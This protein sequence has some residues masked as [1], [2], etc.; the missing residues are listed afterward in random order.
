MQTKKQSFIEAVVNIFI[1]YIVAVLSQML[2][3]PIFDIQTSVSDN[4]LI[5]L[6]F[7]AVGLCRVYILRR[8][9]N[10]IHRKQYA[11][12]INRH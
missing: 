6:Y 2:I 1:G 10:K 12:A 3:F 5:A 7:T 9:F 4:L 11:E 8:M